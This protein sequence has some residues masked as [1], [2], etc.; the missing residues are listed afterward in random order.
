MNDNSCQYRTSDYQGGITIGEKPSL[1]LAHNS[2]T[3]MF[4]IIDRIL[5]GNGPH[6]E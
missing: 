3:R 1:A 2:E 6:T 4:F 5:A